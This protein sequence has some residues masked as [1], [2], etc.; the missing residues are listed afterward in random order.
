MEVPALWLR[1]RPQQ[2][3]ARS[4]CSRRRLPQG[5]ALLAAIGS[6]IAQQL[7]SKN[8]TSR[9][10]LPDFMDSSA[11]LVLTALVTVLGV[12]LHK[13]FPVHVKQ[14]TKLAGW[15]RSLAERLES[16]PFVGTVVVLILID[17][18]CMV[19]VTTNVGGG[20]LT[21]IAEWLGFRCLM[22]F[23]VEQGLHLLAF[24]VDFFGHPWFVLDL[25][26]VSITA[27]VELK[28]ELL[29][30]EWKF[31]TCVRLWKLASFAFDLA[32]VREEG[33]ELKEL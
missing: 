1:A 8:I 26:S 7:S 20:K 19:Q 21:E 31:V 9:A 11:L 6:T 12:V 32:L 2:E 22:A 24:G 33:K 23:L 15:Q 3:V 13:F 25:I 29:L 30:D 27:V 28:E 17:L 18:C 5:A 16:K 4:R 10:M 14:H